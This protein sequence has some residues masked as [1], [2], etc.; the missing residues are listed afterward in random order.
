MRRAVD[1]IFWASIAT[2]FFIALFPTKP[3]HGGTVEFTPPTVGMKSPICCLADT[4]ALRG[5]YSVAL[6][7]FG[8][9]SPTWVANADSLKLW[10]AGRLPK[11]HDARWVAI[12]RDFVIVEAAPRQVASVAVCPPYAGKRSLSYPDSLR[13]RAGYV[14]ARNSVGGFCKS[15]VVKFLP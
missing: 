10:L 7:V 13:G 6:F 1:V 5:C 11:S 3:A 9:Q 12:W 4:V 8:Q 14:V 15:N 2:L